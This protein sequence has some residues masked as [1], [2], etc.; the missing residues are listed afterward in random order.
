MHS[1]PP[2]MYLVNIET[3]YLPRNQHRC[4][5]IRSNVAMYDIIKISASPLCMPP[6]CCTLP[7][8]RE[9]RVTLLRNNSRQQRFANHVAKIIDAHSTVISSPMHSQSAHTDADAT[10]SAL[11]FTASEMEP[12]EENATR[13]NI[14]GERRRCVLFITFDS[15][16]CCSTSSFH[17]LLLIYANPDFPTAAASL[18]NRASSGSRIV[19]KP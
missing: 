13:T 17:Q 18:E 15:C 7:C 5:K 10:A 1:V 16:C 14:A 8:T 11:W 3:R 4:D 6:Y 19:K 9:N 2:K 12:R